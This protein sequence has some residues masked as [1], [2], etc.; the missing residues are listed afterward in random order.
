MLGRCFAPQYVHCRLVR[1]VPFGISVPSCRAFSACYSLRATL[2]QGRQS[3]G[4]MVREVLRL[5][6]PPHITFQFGYQQG[7]LEFNQS[8]PFSMTAK[9]GMAGSVRD[10]AFPAC[11]RSSAVDEPS[12]RM[13]KAVKSSSV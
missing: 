10:G 12:L 6:V 3:E 9:R 13:A 5:M 4:S 8:F 7:G 1:V 11:R 2:Q